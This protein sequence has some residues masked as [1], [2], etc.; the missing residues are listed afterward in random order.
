MR[1]QIVYCRV[2]PTYSLQWNYRYNN[3]RR[4]TTN[5]GESVFWTHSFHK[6]LRLAGWLVY[7]RGLLCMYVHWRILEV[8]AGYMSLWNKISKDKITFIFVMSTAEVAEPSSDHNA[9]QRI[10]GGSLTTINQYPFAVV[11]LY[12]STQTTFSQRCGGSILNQRSVLSAA[13][14]PWGYVLYKL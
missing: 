4:H 8:P 2:D 11:L 7:S 1:T 13:H 9:P 10:I 6:V 5:N 14:C 12:S 3:P